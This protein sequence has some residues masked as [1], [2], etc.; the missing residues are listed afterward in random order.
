MQ[1]FVSGD[2]LAAL[3]ELYNDLGADIN[4]L[5]SETGLSIG[6]LKKSQNLI[7]YA[8]CAYLLEAAAVQLKRPDFALL[9][10]QKRAEAGYAR[11]IA[12]YSR[13]AKNIGLAIQGHVDHL[14]TRTLGIN[15]ALETDDRCAWFSRSI[16]PQASHGFPQATLL[17]FASMCSF[18][19]DISHQKWSP[20]SVSFTF[21][22]PADITALKS[23]FQCPLLF[24]ADQD[25]IFFNKALLSLS[26]A[27]RDDTIHQMLSQYLTSL[28]LSAGPDFKPFVKSMILNNLSAGRSDI[29]ALSLRLP[30]RPRTIQR[31]LRDLGTSYKEVLSEARFELAENLLVSSDNP[32]THIAHRL[33]FQDLSAFSKA[34]KKHY[35]VSPREW[36]KTML[37]KNNRLPITTID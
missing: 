1:S 18:L 34:F 19:R 13:A 33:C 8:S 20:L 15:Y 31:K 10:S 9:L 6:A 5:L 32:L 30:Y 11:E 16:S 2:Y 23:H 37:A 35:G 21:K 25:A 3:P 14:R 36:K 27:T 7:P 17:M 29:E 12:A 4:Q 26:L 24:D 28:H 22:K